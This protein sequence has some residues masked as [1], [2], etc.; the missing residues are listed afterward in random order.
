LQKGELG[1]ILQGMHSV[2]NIQGPSTEILV[3]HASFIDFLT[4]K[5]R[6]GPFFIDKEWHHQSL[7]CHWL[8]VL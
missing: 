1:L 2:L 3:Y 8:Q 7:V 4:N 6:S 5:S